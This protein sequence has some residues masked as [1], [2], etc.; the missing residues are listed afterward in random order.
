[1]PQNKGRF[2]W[3]EG[4]GMLGNQSRGIVRHRT[5][6]RN[7]RRV[8]KTVGRANQVFGA[9]HRLTRESVTVSALSEE[10]Y[11]D[12]IGAEFVKKR[13]NMENKM[14]VSL[15]RRGAAKPQFGPV[16]CEPG[17]PTNQVRSLRALLGSS[18][19]KRRGGGKIVPLD[20][21]ANYAVRGKERR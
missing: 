11:A 21:L 18:L 12:R 3:H 15:F 9:G 5:I 17:L 8:G 2:D 19:T 7:L 13:L 20:V 4:T 16:F 1:M 6:G 10:F 14:A